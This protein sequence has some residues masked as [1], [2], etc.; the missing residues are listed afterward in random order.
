MRSLFN[1]AC[2]FYG[3]E[4]VTGSDHN[5]EILKFFSDTGHEWVRDDETA[6]CSAFMNYVAFHSGYE[7]SGELTARSWLNVGYEI[8]KPQIGCIVV[9]WRLNP[10]SWK[11]HVGLYINSD[12]KY[13]YILGGNQD[14]SVCVKR[15]PKE[16][17]LSYRMLNRL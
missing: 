12:D 9:L 14:N 17:L 11:G 13:I 8:K 4:E 6:W 5:P 2:K 3:L 1:K 16:R 7:R 10:A 15:Y